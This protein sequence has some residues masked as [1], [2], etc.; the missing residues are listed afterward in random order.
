M[1]SIN[2]ENIHTEAYQR[3][4]DDACKDVVVPR[5][6]LRI[7]IRGQDDYSANEMQTSSVSGLP[8]ILTQNHLFISEFSNHCA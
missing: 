4:S 5:S 1:A 7:Q 8:I 3:E 2:D 6:R